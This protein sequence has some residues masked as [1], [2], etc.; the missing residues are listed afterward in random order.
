[1]HK[2]GVHVR[3]ITDDECM[4]NPGSDI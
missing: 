2:S 4:N 1:V 3:V